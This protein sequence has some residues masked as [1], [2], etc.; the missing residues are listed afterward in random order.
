M[1]SQLTLPGLQINA[2]LILDSYKW[3]ILQ[4]LIDFYKL[5]DYDNNQ[6][7]YNIYKEREYD[8]YLLKELKQIEVNKMVDN[9]TMNSV[10][11]RDRKRP[12]RCPLEIC[13][14]CNEE[15]EYQLDQTIWIKKDYIKHYLGKY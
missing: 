10:I 8:N 2:S 6:I 4:N 15:A 13:Y 9:K 11:I 5:Q 1:A 12:D 14:F 7:T 3:C